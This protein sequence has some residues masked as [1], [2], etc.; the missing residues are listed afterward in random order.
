MLSP[1]PE[2]FYFSKKPHPWS[3]RLASVKICNLLLQL[4][5][6]VFAQWQ[7]RGVVGKTNIYVVKVEVLTYWV[8]RR[9]DNLRFHVT[10]IRDEYCNVS[11]FP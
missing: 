10:A 4:T 5:V 3:P 8:S 11:H 7:L 9:L 6:E 1:T 2:V